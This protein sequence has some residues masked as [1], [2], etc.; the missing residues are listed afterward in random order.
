MTT[1]IEKYQL[2]LQREDFEFDPSQQKAVE[3][4][5][6]LFDE[7]IAI[8]N[9]PSLLA[10]IRAALFKK[11]ETTKGL[12]F[13]GGVGRGKTYLVD[14]FYSCLPFEEK[15][16]IHFHRFMQSIH[17]QL[18]AL[19]NTESPLTLIADDIASKTRVI[20]FDEFH[21]SDITDAMLLA[22][23]FEALFERGVVLVATSNQH[24][25]DLYQGGLQ[26]ER[27]LPAIALIKSHTRVVNIDSGIDYRLKFLDQAEIYHVPLDDQ[28]EA[29]LRNNFVHI[30]PDEGVANKTLEIE[31]REIET[32]LCGDGVAWFEF[33]AL[34]DGP[35]GPAD[36][37]ELAR[38]FQTVLL[39]N[40]TVMTDMENDLAKR[41]MTL[42]D[43][44][45][46]RHVK[47]IV[48][49]EAEPVDLYTG[50]R[51]AEGF[52]RTVSRL[53]EMRTHD[54]LAKQHLS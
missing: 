27:F 41:F 49:A 28:A 3:C 22:G 34:C 23:L 9:K 15:M 44:F 35:R 30:S 4:I 11:N 47:L 53:E 45:Y 52:K 38:Q 7:L 42:I 36:Y 18:K 39:A 33:V 43:E 37:I 8:E 29:M 21:V 32:V 50:K 14:C 24:P 54:Y 5:Q 25:D 48:T 2:D 10:G 20:C 17:H 46:D 1:P 12:Y 51:L 13:W 16:R 31:G 6:V 19:K 26:R 40:V